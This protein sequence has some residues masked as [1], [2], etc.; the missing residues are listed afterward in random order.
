MCERAAVPQDH[1][2]TRACAAIARYFFFFLSN[3]SCWTELV[4]NVCLRGQAGMISRSPNFG[5]A[6][7]L[8]AA[9]AIL[10]K[11]IHLRNAL[12]GTF[13]IAKPTRYARK[14]CAGVQCRRSACF[15]R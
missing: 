12:S 3:A 1:F 13:S 15:Y 8:A 6:V 9:A 2:E 11:S 14:E 7:L 10:A 4:A 5:Q